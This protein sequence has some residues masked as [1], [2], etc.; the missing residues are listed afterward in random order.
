MKNF[1]KK[2]AGETIVEVL[3]STVLLVSVLAAAF[4]LL[5]R[6][7][8]ANV[9]IENRIVAINIA[10]EGVEAV[11]NIRDTNWLKYSGTRREKWLCLEEVNW[12][13]PNEITNDCFPSQDAGNI[14]PGF[15]QVDFSSD[16]KRYFLLKI[17]G[18]AALD[19]QNQSAEYA[20]FQLW[21]TND[22]RFMHQ[23]D[24]NVA[25]EFYRQVD[26]EPISVPGGEVKLRVTARVQW[27][28]EGEQKKMI[29]ETYL[30]D[31]YERNAY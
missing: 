3:V 1:W 6:G 24:G 31:F 21:K 19:V 22:G 8:S 25:T 11:R 26:L 23:Q 27:H 2:N 17:D 29:F 28:E 10:R 14:G 13:D 30:F 7:S 18:A 15:Y 9:N 20:Q 16:L 4:V 5:Q 12:G